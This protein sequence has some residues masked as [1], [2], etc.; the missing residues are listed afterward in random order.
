MVDFSINSDKILYMTITETAIKNA[1]PTLKIPETIEEIDLLLK[2]L[3]KQQYEDF[4]NRRKIGNII[5]Q[6]LD[7]RFEITNK[8]PKKSI[9]KANLN[10]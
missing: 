9:K 4:D 2:E 6:V 10:K 8:I 1:Q 3:S 5:D 7:K